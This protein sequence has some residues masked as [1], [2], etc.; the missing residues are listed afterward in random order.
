MYE[1]QDKVELE[2]KAIYTVTL[3]VLA[4]GRLTH[5]KKERPLVEGLGNH[6]QRHKCWNNP[7]LPN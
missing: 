3:F 2:T 7:G 4:V 5:L 1:S 6:F